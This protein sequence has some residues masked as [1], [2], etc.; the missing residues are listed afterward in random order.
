M[1]VHRERVTVDQ[2]SKVGLCVWRGARCMAGLAEVRYVGS[3]PPA[4]ARGLPL[5]YSLS[6]AIG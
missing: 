6:N 1:V 5:Q 4:T 2:G 3:P